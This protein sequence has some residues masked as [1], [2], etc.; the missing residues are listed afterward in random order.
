MHIKTVILLGIFL[1]FAL[2]NFGNLPTT[3]FIQRFL[4]F[5]LSFS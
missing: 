3:F 2:I 1:K 5:F 4:T